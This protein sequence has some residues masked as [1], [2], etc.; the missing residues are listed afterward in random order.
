MLQY[1][2]RYSPL[3]E[4]DLQDECGDIVESDK[5]D[6]ERGDLRP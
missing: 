3:S 4:R 1:I 6:S 5:G 2:G